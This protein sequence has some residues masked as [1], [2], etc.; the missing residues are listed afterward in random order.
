MY[1]ADWRLTVALPL[2]VSL[3]IVASVF[4]F[5]HYRYEQ[6]LACLLWK[7]DMR[8]VTT[9]PTDGEGMGRS[10][11]HICPSARQH[12]AYTA[13]GPGEPKRAYTRIGLYKGKCFFRGH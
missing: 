2:A 1:K 13:A 12:S 11:L 6:K 5:K 4:A 8:D 7:I 10:V 3:A 9:I